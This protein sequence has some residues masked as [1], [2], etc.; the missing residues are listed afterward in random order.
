MSRGEDQC[1]ITRSP[2]S[3]HYIP[4]RPA[5]LVRRLGDE[6]AVTIFERQQ[7]RRLCQL[8]EAT[9]HHE[10]RSRL[11][12]IK[13]AYA[14]FDP[15]DDAATQFSLTDAERASRCRALFDDFDALLMR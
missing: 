1:E 11:E 6:P 4:L 8:V 12:E 2:T 5:D 14:P 15:D 13:A 7:F 9:I 10:Y 3:D